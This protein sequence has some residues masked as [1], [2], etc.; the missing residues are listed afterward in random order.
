MSY[1][2]SLVKTAVEFHKN[3]P[4]VDEI[5]LKPDNI[6]Q[7]MKHLENGLKLEAHYSMQKVDSYNDPTMMCVDLHGNEPGIITKTMT[8]KAHVYRR[9]K[10]S[11]G[12]PLFEYN[13]KPPKEKKPNHFPETLNASTGYFP[14]RS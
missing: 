11:E 9:I 12:L 14:S 2:D 3:K 6:P 10:E 8:D 5:P 1:I 4:Q 13:D 7:M